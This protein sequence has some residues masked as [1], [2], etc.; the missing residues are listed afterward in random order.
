MSAIHRVLILHAHPAP[1]KSHA[2][3]HLLQAAQRLE[4]VTV[5][6]LYETYPDFLIDVAAEQDLLTRHDVIILQHPFYWYSAPAL[7]KE[8]LDLVLQYGWAYG[9]NGTALHGKHLLQVV[10]TGGPEEAYGAAGRNRHRM[11]DF[12]LPFDQSARLCGMT[13]LAPWVVFGVGRLDDGALAA[14]AQRY[15]SLLAALR[16]GQIDLNQAAE[17]ATLQEVFHG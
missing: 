17:A 15:A 9:E 14:Q 12:L 3:R 16:D 1:H 2:N 5:R 4:G 11:R 13:Y 8:W 10:T 6:S 7:V